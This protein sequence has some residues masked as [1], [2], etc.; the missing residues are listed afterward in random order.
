MKR[1]TFLYGA[2]A[3]V[4]GLAAWR[5]A[6]S[7]DERAIAK[8]IYKKLGYLK[9]DPAGVRQFAADVSAHKAI[10]SLRLRSIDALGPLYTGYSLSPN[11]HLAEAITH[12]ED[13]VTTLY[14]MSSDFFRNGADKTQTVHYL[15]YYDPVVACNNPFARPPEAAASPPTT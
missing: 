6:G 5:A 10:S 1:R 4:L 13:K 2:A 9:L 12:G 7:R 8:V 3:G 11:G 14:L 15:G